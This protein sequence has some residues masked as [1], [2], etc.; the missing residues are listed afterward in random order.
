MVDFEPY[1]VHSCYSNCLA[2]P[3]STMFIKDY[4]KVYRERGH[5]V[6]CMSEHGNRSNV[7]EQFDIC[8]NFKNDKTNPYTMTPLAAAEAYFV[9]DRKALIDGKLDSRNFHLILVAKNMEGFYQLNEILSEANL[10]GYYYRA[11]LDFELLSK[12]NYKNFLCTTACVAGI[13][14]DPNFEK[15]ACQLHEIFR[16]NFYLEVQHHPQQIQVETNMK[17]LRMYQKYRWPLIYGTDS[18][19]INREDKI[20][21]TELMLSKGIT[22]GDED[23]FD[24]HLPTAEEAFTLMQN[25]GVLV[26]ARIE[27]AMENTLI[28][29][30]FEGVSFSREKKIPNSNRSMSQEE[31][32]EL[33]KT[34]CREKYEKKAEKPNKEEEKEIENELDAVAD[35]NTSDYF[36]LCKEIVDRGKEK[37]GVITK[38]GRGSGSSF[39]TNFALGFTS[40]N[41]LHS[42]VKLYPERFISKER[43]AAGILPD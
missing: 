5:R 18:H 28:L 23:S 21:R 7:W 9:P 15:L 29:R 13:W 27:E 31:R 37:G 38:T 16:E 12:L 2:Q 42:P 22:Y 19:Y 43:M 34:L 30:E 3:D 40:L 26:K 41:R 36:L 10:T 1:H 4:A 20:L 8:E 25:Q 33:Y 24:L 6:L 32:N 39:C 17:V 11:R 14:K 35:T